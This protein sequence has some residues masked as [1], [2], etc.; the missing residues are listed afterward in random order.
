MAAL[1]VEW[2]NLWRHCRTGFREAESPM[3][4]PWCESKRE[5]LSKTRLPKSDHPVLLPYDQ[6]WRGKSGWSNRDDS[7]AL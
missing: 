1:P 3:L 5:L 7:G 2:V 4:L 6:V